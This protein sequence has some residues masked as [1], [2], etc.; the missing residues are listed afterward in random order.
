MTDGEHVVVTDHGGTHEP[1]VDDWIIGRYM[2]DEWL[3]EDGKGYS[4]AIHEEGDKTLDGFIAA[5][6]RVEST[7]VTLHQVW[8]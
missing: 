6:E 7:P 1:T 2:D 5:L 4:D 8:F 3:C